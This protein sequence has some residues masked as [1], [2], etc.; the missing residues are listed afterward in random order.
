VIFIKTIGI[1]SNNIDDINLVKSAPI[2]VYIF[3]C[4]KEEINIKD[5]INFLY[6]NKCRDIILMNDNTKKWKS[7]YKNIKFYNNFNQIKKYANKKVVFLYNMSKRKNVK[8]INNI[9]IISYE[10]NNIYRKDANPIETIKNIKKILKRNGINPKEKRRIKTINNIYS[11]R[12]EI[13]ENIGT[14]GKGLSLNL[15]KASAYSELIE[16]LQTNMLIKTRGEKK[17]ICKEKKLYKSL[18]YNASSEYRKK[19]YK[20]DDVYFSTENFIN[21]KNNTEKMLPINSI[22]CFCHTNGLASGNSFNEAVNQGI[23][24]TLERYCYKNLLSN[25]I[26]V[27]NIDIEKY[28]INKINSSIL[29]NIKE[30]NMLVYIKDCSLGKY[31]VIGLM[32]MNKEKNKYAFTIA[33]DYSFDI[34]LSRCLTEMFQGLTFNDLKNKMHE[35]ISLNKLNNKY[36]NGYN[37]YNWLCCFQNNNG[38]LTKNFFCN[39]FVSIKELKFDNFISNNKDVLNLLKKEINHDIYVKSYNKIK[40]DTYRVYIPYMSDVDC[41][42]IDDIDVYSNFEKLAYIYTHITAISNSELEYF[43]DLLFKLL[44]N[45]KYEGLIT[46]A[47]LFHVNKET[48]YYKLNFTWLVIILSIKLKREKELCELLKFK[49][50]NFNLD[51]EQIKIYKGIVNDIGNRKIYKFV[52]SNKKINTE[53]EKMKKNINL[54]IVNLNP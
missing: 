39:E 5:A 19:F 53:I 47:K 20:L 48:T 33:A 35:T 25:N 28:P 51:K 34:A 32:I 3:Y 45:I 18:L 4:I 15:A 31:P 44:K 8:Q 30:K 40:F 46:P 12:I 21:I 11:V 2:N 37:S 6:S 22:N 36:K 24:E 42:D 38:Y 14:N 54:Y 41:Y 50:K 26:K 52:E 17:N 16:R 13:D 1:I 43:T 29:K 7:L 23:F 27:K 49:I 9:N 10:N